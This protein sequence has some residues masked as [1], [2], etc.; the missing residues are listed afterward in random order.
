MTVNNAVRGCSHMA[1]IEVAVNSVRVRTLDNKRVI[2]LTDTSKKRHLHI[3]IGAE[4]TGVLISALQGDKRPCHIAYPKIYDRIDGTGGS[5]LK[6]VVTNLEG[7]EYKAKLVVTHTKEGP[8]EVNCTA[9]EAIAVAIGEGAPVYVEETV[10]EKAGIQID[11]RDG[12]YD[13]S[14]RRN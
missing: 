3:S 6:A 10:M 4:E 8:A 7:R 14:G 12:P 11:D 5:V 13:V 9:S 1:E 2:N